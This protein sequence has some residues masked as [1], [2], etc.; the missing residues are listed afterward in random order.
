[1]HYIENSKPIHSYFT[2][3]SIQIYVSI[4]VIQK[5]NTFDFPEKSDIIYLKNGKHTQHIP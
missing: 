5:K 3:Y 1:M 4:Y 2:Y